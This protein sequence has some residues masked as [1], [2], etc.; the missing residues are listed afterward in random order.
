MN[1]TLEEGDVLIDAARTG[2][3]GLEH[4]YQIGAQHNKTG[5]QYSKLIRCEQS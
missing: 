2:W 1:D 5:T 3:R 4:T